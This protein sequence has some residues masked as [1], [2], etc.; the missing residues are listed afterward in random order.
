[1]S[2]SIEHLLSSDVLIH[3]KRLANRHQ[4]DEEFRR[5]VVRN[6][7]SILPLFCCCLTACL[8]VAAGVAAAVRMV[9]HIFFPADAVLPA[10]TGKAIGSTSFAL[11]M[12]M[13]IGRFYLSTRRLLLWLE[14]LMQDEA[15][16]ATWDK[17]D[18]WYRNAPAAKHKP[19]RPG[20][21]WYHESPHDLRLESRKHLIPMFLHQHPSSKNDPVFDLILALFLASPIIGALWFFPKL[22]LP[23]VALLF[24]G[25]IVFMALSH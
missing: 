23:L 21:P 22:F 8:V 25:L 18:P 19:W 16:R 15:R 4:Q 13:L 24:I 20:K 11:A 10:L 7:G 12:L 1:M 9:P 3:A 17:K 6:F 2:H 5:Y 14:R